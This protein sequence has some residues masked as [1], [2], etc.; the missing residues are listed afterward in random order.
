MRQHSVI[1]A[2]IKASSEFIIAERAQ[3]HPH[4]NSNRHVQLPCS[5]APSTPRPFKC[6]SPPQERQS[7]D[8]WTRDTGARSAMTATLLLLLPPLLLLCSSGG[9]AQ[10]PAAAVQEYYIA[11][12]EIGWDY[13]YLD[14]VDPAS[15]QRWVC[16]CLIRATHSD[17]TVWPYCQFP[18]DGSLGKIREMSTVRAF[19]LSVCWVLESG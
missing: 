9:G 7:R 12:V 1:S 4:I 19:C 17:M 11:A 5:C 2:P 6:L 13:V 14:D 15:D 18:V 8:R 10:Q 3:S 16:I